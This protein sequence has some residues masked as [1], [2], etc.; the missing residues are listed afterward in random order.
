M[1]SKIPPEIKNILLKLPPEK[2]E[3]SESEAE[4]EPEPKPEGVGPEGVEGPVP[5]EELLPPSSSSS[6]LFDF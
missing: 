3:V 4:P 5:P 2:L 1:V 6:L